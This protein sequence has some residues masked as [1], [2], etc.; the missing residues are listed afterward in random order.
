[1]I[2]LHLVTEAGEADLLMAGL[3]YTEKQFFSSGI[4]DPYLHDCQL[5]DV[6]LLS[7]HCK[8]PLSAINS[9]VLT[10]TANDSSGSCV[11]WHFGL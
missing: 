8:L 3:N 5:L 4:S 7:P 6:C 9:I 2:H 10:T 11:E 1:M